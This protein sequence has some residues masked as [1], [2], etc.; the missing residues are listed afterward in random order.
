[1]SP[2]ILQVITD[3]KLAPFPSGAQWWDKTQLKL[4]RIFQLDVMKIFH[5]KGSQSLESVEIPSLDLFRTWLD[6]TEQPDLA[7]RFSVF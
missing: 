3:L 6:N 5:H 4:Q 2:C 1:M 7:Q